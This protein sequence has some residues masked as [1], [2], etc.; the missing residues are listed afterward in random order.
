MGLLSRLTIIIKAKMN[1]L[2]DKA[3]DPRETLDYSYE[4]QVEL[5]RNVKQGIVEVVASKHRLQY[6][7]DQ[8]RKS[9]P[10]LEGQ[11]RRALT[12][13]REDL[14][15]LVLQRKQAALQQLQDL[16]IQTAG[17]EQEQVKLTA[18]EQRLKAKVEVFRTQKEVI[19]AQYSASEAQ[20]RIGESLS[21]LSEEMSDVGASIDRARQKT[22]QMR[23]RASAI[24]EL[25]KVGV[26]DDFT[27][28]TDQV[29][30][31]LAKLTAG[32][33]VEEELLVLRRQLPPPVQPQQLAPGPQ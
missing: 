32:Q 33:N 16:D 12:V 25:A 28:G 23:A 24:D 30:S 11:A 21:G 15:R 9:V 8:L 1:R 22:E 2:L 27:E 26:L 18:A 10:Q 31:E 17:L 19:K 20:V 5:L 14:A 13:N 29:S 3:E 4:R 7:A 6:Q